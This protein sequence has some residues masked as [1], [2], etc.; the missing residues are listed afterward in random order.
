[1]EVAIDLGAVE[2][3][4]H[5]RDWLFRKSKTRSIKLRSRVKDGVLIL[6][7]RLRDWRE[8]IVWASG[9]SNVFISRFL[10]GIYN[11][12]AV[13]LPGASLFFALWTATLTA[14][15]T[16]ATAGETAYTSYARVTVTANTTNF[17][18]S[19]AGSAITNATAITWPANTGTASTITF[20][21]IL[22]SAT[23]GAGNIVYWGSITSTTINAGDTPQINASGLTGTEA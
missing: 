16:G 12:S 7:P 18:A 20:L 19:S 4:T 21:A 14:A 11:N 10:N 15:S 13:T 6:R 1:V 8:W 2:W 23:I 22:D 17:P 3:E 5:A 9:K